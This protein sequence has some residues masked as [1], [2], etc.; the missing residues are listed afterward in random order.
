[1]DFRV[2]E[3]FLMVA[4]EENITKAAQI[5]HVSQPTIS[6]QLMQLE[7]EHGIMKNAIDR[8]FAMAQRLSGTKDTAFIICGASEDGWIYDKVDAYFRDAIAGPQVL[9]WNVIDVIHAGGFQKPES[10][11]YYEKAYELGKKMGGTN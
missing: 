11:G 9:G 2:L 3:Y 10:S 4:R 7:E 1:M 6:R 8:F 5:L